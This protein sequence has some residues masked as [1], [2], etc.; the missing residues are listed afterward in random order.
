MF[1]NTIARSKLLMILFFLFSGMHS[2]QSATLRYTYDALGRVT[3]VEDTVNGN[4]DYDYDA[5]G[6]RTQMSVGNPDENSPPPI[7]IPAPPTSLRAWGPI[8]QYGGYS[9]TWVGNDGADYYEL[10]TNGGKYHTIQAG[11]QLKVTDTTR[12]KWVRACNT[13]GCS[14][15]AYF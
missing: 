5:A 15:K 3:F 14:A 11:Q 10:R 8:S 9:A 13:A 2:A 4:R 7:S 6:N 12:A 1:H